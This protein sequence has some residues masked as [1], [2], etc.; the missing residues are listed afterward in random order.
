MRDEDMEGLLGAWLQAAGAGDRAA[1]E[2]LYR[3]FQPRLTRFIQRC[4]SRQH[5]VDEAV[6]D[7]L[8]VVWKG[9]GDFR[10]DS[11]VTTWVHGIAYRCM[12][13]ALRDR[14]VA[15]EI[16]ASAVPDE[17]LAQAEPFFDEGPDRELR[18]WVHQGLAALS[19]E[20]RTTVELAYCQGESCEEIA[21][22]MACPSGT[23]K[24][25]LVRAREKLKDVLPAL[26]E[27]V[28]GTRGH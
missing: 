4:C 18:D 6:N 25:R 8:W 21:R 22:I 9:A 20:Q 17:E 23:V 16:N 10:G 28:I 24:A 5:V 3:H 11:R 27:A 7:A 19:I 12:L 14:E 15:Q 13:K 2:Q 1:F 26:A